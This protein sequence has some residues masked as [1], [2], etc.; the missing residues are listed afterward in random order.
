LR[1]DVLGRAELATITVILL[2]L[3]M[4][5]VFSG[6]HMLVTLKDRIP[7]VFDRRY[8]TNVNRCE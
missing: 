7:L 3:S 4:S 2:L 8:L 1:T 6:S 5:L